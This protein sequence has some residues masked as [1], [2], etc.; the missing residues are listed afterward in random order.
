MATVHASGTQAATLDTEHTLSTITA[1]GIYLLMVDDAARV[2]GETLTLKA[3]SKVLS[4]GT[5]RLMREIIISPAA[6]SGEPAIVDIPRPCG[7]GELQ[8]TL[9]QSGGTGRSYPWTILKL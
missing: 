3:K 1:V 7:D 9:T 8:Y 6:A 2:A 4:G 5:Q